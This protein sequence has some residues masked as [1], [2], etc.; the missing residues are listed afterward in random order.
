MTILLG[1]LKLLGIVLA[2]W[3]VLRLAVAGMDGFGPWGKLL[4]AYRTTQPFTARRWWFRTGYLGRLR[5]AGTLVVGASDEGL[6]VMPHLL[7]VSGSAILV[8]WDHI[9]CSQDQV[10]FTH[11]VVLEL[12]DAPE[13]PLKFMVRLGRRIAA[14]SGGR[15]ALP[16]D[17]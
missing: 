5:Y 8:P 14:G 2:G 9:R 16:D 15:F 13:V 1:S 10:G 6:F 3:L 4:S 11:V 17:L 7:L 12:R